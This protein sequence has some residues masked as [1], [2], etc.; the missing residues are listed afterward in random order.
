L[1]EHVVCPGQEQQRASIEDNK[2]STLRH[3]SSSGSLNSVGTIGSQ[4]KDIP[5]Q[6]EVLKQQKEV[7]EQGIDM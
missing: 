7:W 1:H 2:G 3:A 4:A 6:F 5:Q